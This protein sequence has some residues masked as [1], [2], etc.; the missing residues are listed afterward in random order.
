MSLS[1]VIRN[2]LIAKRTAM[3]MTPISVCVGAIC[4]TTICLAVANISTST[5][6][7]AEWRQSIFTNSTPT[8]SDRAFARNFVKKS[9]SMSISEVSV[10]A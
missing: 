4:S 2:F 9:I 1:S 10:I 5:T 3:A 7:Y 6:V 8:T